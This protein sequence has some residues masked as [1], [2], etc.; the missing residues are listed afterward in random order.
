MRIVAKVPQEIFSRPESLAACA[1]HVATIAAF[2]LRILLVHGHER[3]IDMS[4]TSREQQAVDAVNGCLH[5]QSLLLDALRAAGARAF[6][7]YASSRPFFFSEPLSSSSTGSPL[8]YSRYV[9]GLNRTSV[10]KPWRRWP[11]LV[12]PSLARTESS[13]PSLLHPDQMAAALAEFLRVDQ[14]ILVTELEGIASNHFSVNPVCSEEIDLLPVSNHGK[15]RILLMLEAAK[16][17]V[18]GG[19]P[20]VLITR[21][22]LPDFFLQWSQPR[23]SGTLMSLAPLLPA[24]TRLTPRPA[25]APPPMPPALAPA[26]SL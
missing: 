26:N 19:V 20:S 18:E 23:T 3:Q 21:N 6:D 22:L 11:V 1:Q 12:A 7:L 14:L 4:N 10:K 25:D 9:T 15:G 2:G 16:R 24:G 13:T 5:R 8:R 17:A